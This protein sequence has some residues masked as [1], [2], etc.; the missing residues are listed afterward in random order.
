M[1]GHTYLGGGTGS[2]AKLF[3]LQQETNYTT[4]TSPSGGQFLGK[5]TLLLRRGVVRSEGDTYPFTNSI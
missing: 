3:Y 2:P 1:C 5:P 4:K